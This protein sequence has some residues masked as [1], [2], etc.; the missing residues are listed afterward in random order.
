MSMKDRKDVVRKLARAFARNNVEKVISLC[1]EDVTI[2]DPVG[3]LK[4]SEGVRLWMNRIFNR[5]PKTAIKITRLIG[6]KNRIVKEYLFEGTTP[7]GVTVS[8]PAVGIYEFRGKKVQK[9]TQFY[10]TLTIAQRVVKG[11]LEKRAIN[12]IINQL[13]RE[14]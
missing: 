8:L 14:S 5:F 13:K 1:T 2:I 9:L 12:S 6:E 11:W 7:E 10:D 3:T 4:G